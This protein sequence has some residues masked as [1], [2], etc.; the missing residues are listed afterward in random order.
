M[1]LVEIGEPFGALP[2][3]NAAKNQFLCREYTLPRDEKENCAK[4][5]VERDVRFGPFSD[6]RVCKTH[7]RYSV[8][9]KVPSL[10]EDQTISWIGTVNGFDKVRQRGTVGPRRRQSFEETRCKGETNIEIVINKQLEL[11][12]DGRRKWIDIE[13]KDPRT[14]MA[15]RC[16]N[17]L[18]TIRLEI[19]SNDFGGVLEL[20]SRFEF[21]F[22]RREHYF[23]KV[24]NFW[25]VHVNKPWPFCVHAI[26]FRM[27]WLPRFMMR[28]IH[29]SM[30]PLWKVVQ[31]VR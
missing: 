20:M 5:W 12:S 14:L 26:P 25:C 28:E 15:S 30:K 22:R 6:I 17:S 16:Q 4:G 31:I 21:E 11:Y 27:L 24:S 2:S 19:N 7:G 10:F 18:L 1:N 8:E 23:L 29:I 13:G 9:V 3:P